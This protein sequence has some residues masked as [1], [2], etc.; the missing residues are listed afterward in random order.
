MTLAEPLIPL[1]KEILRLTASKWNE[2]DC[3]L[4]P[5]FGEIV[6]IPHPEFGSRT[7]K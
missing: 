4:F 2:S 5:D 3:L 7:P 1:H 6:L